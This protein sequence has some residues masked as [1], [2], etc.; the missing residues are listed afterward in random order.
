MKWLIMAILVFWIISLIDSGR[1]RPNGACLVKNKYK[2]ERYCKGPRRQFYVFH[3]II[4]NCVSVFSKC[5]RVHKHNE[6]PSLN[7]CQRECA[8][9]MQIIMPPNSTNTTTTTEDPAAG[10]QAV[11]SD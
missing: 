4:L 6:W 8:W 9:H 10:R 1:F 5:Q 7:K 2:N 11:A 3:R